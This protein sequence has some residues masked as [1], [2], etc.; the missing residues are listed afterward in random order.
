MG[1]CYMYERYFSNRLKSIESS[2]EVCVAYKS[3]DFSGVSLRV[4]TG[5]KGLQQSY[6]PHMQP[7]DCSWKL[8][9]SLQR[10][11]SLNDNTT[12]F[13]IQQGQYL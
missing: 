9:L 4:G 11:Q 10:F 12:Q 2:V 6:G 8:L 3:S 5:K 1:N 7:F 13:A